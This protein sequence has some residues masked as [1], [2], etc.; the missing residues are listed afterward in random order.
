MTLLPTKSTKAITQAKQTQSPQWTPLKKKVLQYGNI[1]TQAYYAASNGGYTDVPLHVWGST[2]ALPYAIYEDPYDVANTYSPYEQIFFPAVIDGTHTITASDNVE[3][4]PN[5]ANAI[6]YIK[7]CILDSGNLSG[8]S[9]VN[10]F[11]LTG[12]LDLSPHTYDADGSEDHSKT[13]PDGSN[14]CVDFVMA[15]G[16]FS[17]S[18]GGGASQEVSGVGLDLRY[19]DASNGITTYKVFNMSALRL[20]IIEGDETGWS[21]YQ[22]RYGHG[23]GMSQRGA[24]QRANDGQTYNDILAFY[25]P[26]ASR[27]SLSYTKDALTSSEPITDN[28]NAE[29]DCSDYLKVRSGP[30][31]AYSVVG[32]LP[33][34]ARIAVSTAYVDGGDWHQI[35]FGDADSYVHSDYVSL[36]GYVSPS[37]VTLDSATITLFKGENQTM[38]AT[39]SPENASNK[40]VSWASSDTSIA[41]VNSSGKVTAIGAGEATITVTTEI[42]GYTDTCSVTVEVAVTGVSLDESSIV[43]YIGKSRTL[44]A[45]IEPTDATDKSV[46]WSS[47]NTSIAT[48]TAG[49]ISALSEGTATITVTTNDGGYTDDCIVTV[50][51]AP[52]DAIYSS[53]YTVDQTNSL[54]LGIPDEATLSQIIANLDNL[55]SDIVILDSEGVQISDLTSY[56]GTGMKVQLKDGTTVVDE[57]DI[58]VIGDVD[59]DGNN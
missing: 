1:I 57:L 47:S 39:V 51:I 16:S 14:D 49:V 33:T 48:V 52:T 13:L 38:V 26:Y 43:T 45:T 19:F 2:A 54:L 24:Q 3:G 59:G 8:V 36:D 15:T 46:T 34:G 37:G 35:N 29:V 11:S 28:S 17:V 56:A 50:G 4:T 7:K 5:S 32:T 31:T 27:V 55:P 18:V 30:G 58:V 12:V 44:T 9:S 40:N 42:G 10:D 21:I 53:I 20:F 25:Y 41:T 22:R 6:A 23:V